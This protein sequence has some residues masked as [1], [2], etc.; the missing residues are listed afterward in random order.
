MGA[1]IIA[2]IPSRFSQ[3]TGRS[4][5]AHALARA[6]FGRWPGTPGNRRPSIIRTPGN[7]L[8]SRGSPRFRRLTTPTPVGI[9]SVW[10]WKGRWW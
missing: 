5:V 4:R 8:L 7:R 10:L 2:V 3:K 6:I 1:F 9:T